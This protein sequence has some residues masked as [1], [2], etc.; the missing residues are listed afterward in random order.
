M[1]FASAPGEEVHGVSHTGHAL[2][3]P[4]QFVILLVPALQLRVHIRGEQAKLQS[5]LSN[6]GLLLSNTKT[7]WKTQTKIS[8]LSR[9]QINITVKKQQLVLHE[10]CITLVGG[11]FLYLFIRY[12]FVWTKLL[13]NC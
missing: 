6:R 13:I 5:Q 4:H 2:V 3:L 12:I 8:T 1:L 7:Q 11:G 9:V 10:F